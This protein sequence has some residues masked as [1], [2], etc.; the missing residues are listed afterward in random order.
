M[1]I[2]RQRQWGSFQDPW[3]VAIAHE[4]VDGGQEQSI[5]HAISKQCLKHIGPANGINPPIALFGQKLDSSRTPNFGAGEVLHRGACLLQPVS[6]SGV[7][8][9]GSKNVNSTV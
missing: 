1:K 3:G 5:Q 4:S 6:I 9:G 2:Q 7:G 8:G